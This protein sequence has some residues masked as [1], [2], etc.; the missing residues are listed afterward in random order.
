MSA[1]VPPIGPWL[2]LQLPSKAGPVGCAVD[3]K[4]QTLESGR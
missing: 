1:R 3:Q 4:G 2:T